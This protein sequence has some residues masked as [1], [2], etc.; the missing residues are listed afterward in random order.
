MTAAGTDRRGRLTP[1]YWPTGLLTKS[2]SD[3]VVA[4]ALFVYHLSQCGAMILP[5]LSFSLSLFLRPAHPIFFQLHPFILSRSR[6]SSLFQSRTISWSIF[7]DSRELFH[8]VGLSP[9][10]GTQ[11]CS[12][13]AGSS[14]QVLHRKLWSLPVCYSSITLEF[15]AQGTNACILDTNSS[16]S[17]CYPAQSARRKGSARSQGLGTKSRDS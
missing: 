17:K 5:F 12:G 6:L 11:F 3:Y 10:R 15:S 1:C 16:R 7:F 4:L 8:L 13:S 9:F 14:R 2:V